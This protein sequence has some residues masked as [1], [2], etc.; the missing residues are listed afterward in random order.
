MINEVSTR[1]DPDAVW[2]RLLWSKIDKNSCISHRLVTRNP[3]DFV[4]SHDKD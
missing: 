1:C 2:V 4:V 3:G